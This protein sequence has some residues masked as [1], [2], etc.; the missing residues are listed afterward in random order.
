MNISP[1]KTQESKF[2]KEVTKFD[3]QKEPLRFTIKFFHPCV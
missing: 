3:G 1:V 2:H